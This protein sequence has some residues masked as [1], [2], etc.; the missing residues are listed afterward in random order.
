[1][2]K[3]NITGSVKFARKTITINYYTKKNIIVKITMFVNVGWT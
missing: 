3:R 1:M 2:L